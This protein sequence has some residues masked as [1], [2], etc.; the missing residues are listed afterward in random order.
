VIIR[1]GSWIPHDQIVAIK[2]FNITELSHSATQQFMNEANI[3]QK[4]RFN[5][6]VGIYGICIEKCNYYIIMDYIENG[7]LHQLLHNTN[8]K[9]DWT[10]KLKLAYDLAKGINYL[11]LRQPPIL[12]RDIKSL[13]CLVD[14]CNV[15][16]ISD[17]GLAKIK[18]ETSSANSKQKTGAIGTLSWMAPE[19]F[20]IANYT[21]ACDVYSF[22]IVLW[23]IATQQLPYQGLQRERIACIVTK[24][25]RMVIPH[26]VPKPYRQL[27]EECWSH[28]PKSR[29]DFQTIVVRIKNIIFHAAVS[30]NAIIPISNSTIS[31][32]KGDLLLN[33]WLQSEKNLPEL[34]EA[35]EKCNNAQAQYKLA[36][37]IQLGEHGH[38]KDAALAFQWF[39]RSAEQGNKDAEFAVFQCYVDGIGIEKDEKYAFEWSLKAAEH[40][41][42]E[43]T[44]QIGNCYY[45]GIGCRADTTVSF[46]WYLKAV[47]QGHIDAMVR[48]AHC[49]K[50]GWGCKV[51][52]ATKVAAF[53]LYQRSASYGSLE[54][55][56]WL[57]QCYFFGI[58]FLESV[59]TGILWC[60]KSAELGYSDAQNFIGYCMEHGII[61]ADISTAQDMYKKASEQGHIEAS[62]RLKVIESNNALYKKWRRNSNGSAVS[63]KFLE[64]AA[65]NGFALAQYEL[66]CC[67]QKGMGTTENQL[68]AFKWFNKSAHN[69]NIAAAYELGKCYETGT[70]C[71]T[72]PTKSAKWYTKAAKHNNSQARVALLEFDHG[73]TLFD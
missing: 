63:F 53:Q 38:K 17:F 13:N 70:G 34:I 19:L 1:L 27:I 65:I 39:K 56:Y 49:Y 15:V 43:A 11:H 2:K 71:T 52:D 9:L 61:D 30:I 42:L 24:G 59:E 55:T 60:S 3:M 12:H 31:L 44:Y 25:E 66:A 45:K 20:K 37:Y 33:K 40:E 35:A 18:Y 50:N 16:K 48:L 5:H 21:K 57:G 10:M 64:L 68:Q 23:E 29:P 58:G 4:M 67:Y 54:G 6:I 26:D 46:Q 41:H 51:N 62:K 72:N 28:S 22:G 14:H 36:Q 7:S 32:D 47:K 8:K 69:G 73:R